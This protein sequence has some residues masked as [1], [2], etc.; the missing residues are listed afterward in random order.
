MGNFDHI[1]AAKRN[2]PPTT[3]PPQA[4][5]PV[6]Q[7]APAPAYTPPPPPVQTGAS[8]MAF[9][10]TT[11]QTAAPGLPVLQFD[12]ASVWPLMEQMAEELDAAFKAA[13]AT[14]NIEAYIGRP[15]RFEFPQA[16]LFECW[17][18]PHANDPHLT[19]RVSAHIA[20]EAKPGHRFPVEHVITVTDRGRSKCWG[21]FGTVTAAD[22]LGIVQHL[23]QRRARPHLATRLREATGPF[24]QI[25]TRVENR[26][27]AV[28]KDWEGIFLGL[29]AVVLL[30]PPVTPLGILLFWWLMRRPTAMR[31]SGKPEQEPRTLQLF[32]SWQA[33]LSGAAPYADTMR[34]RFLNVLAACPMEEFAYET[35]NLRFRSLEL[36]EEREQIVLRAK[37]GVIYCQIYQFGAD[38]YVGWQSFINLGRWV[39]TTIASGVDRQSGQRVQL[40]CAVPGTQMPNE[41]NYMDLSCLTEWSHVQI[42]N[43]TRQLMKE[44]QIEQEI[45]F[46]I[47]RGPRTTIGTT[48][49]HSAGGTGAVGGVRRFFQ[50]KA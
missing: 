32:D 12:P 48:T 40:N 3:P 16:V 33:V 17:V 23:V 36:L 35:E 30:F 8:P 29:L 41:Y 34:E 5:A 46:Q 25:F 7:S 47:V 38:L 19:E 1:L 24:W 6:P 10:R 49:G 45:D 21:R 26:L 9:G 14:F 4:A 37:R 28:S 43:L 15:N 31:S 13:C 44:L 11:Q 42:A 20:L 50:R 2:A 18:R 27:D 22:V 39:E